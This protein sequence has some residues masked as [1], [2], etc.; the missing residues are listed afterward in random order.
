MATTRYD[1]ALQLSEPGA[2]QT[3]PAL[4]DTYRGG[5]DMRD[6]TRSSVLTI[7][8]TLPTV[9]GGLSDG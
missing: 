2:A 6:A 7:H 3:A 8:P 1:R 4:T 5:V 9:A